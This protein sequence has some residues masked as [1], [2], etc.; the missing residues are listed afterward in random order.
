[1]AA[2]WSWWPRLVFP[3]VC[4]FHI[5][6]CW[7]NLIKVNVRNL[8]QMV[9]H[10]SRSSW[11]GCWNGEGHLVALLVYMWATV[12]SASPPLAAAHSSWARAPPSWVPRPLGAIFQCS[13][14]GPRAIS[15]I[16]ESS[17]EI[18]H[19]PMTGLPRLN[20]M[21]FLC[22]WLAFCQLSLAVLLIVGWSG[23]LIGPY[24]HPWQIKMNYYLINAIGLA[25]AAFQ[26]M[27]PW[28]SKEPNKR[29]SQKG[30]CWLS[31]DQL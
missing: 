14:R 24:M 20:E 23:A 13:K 28:S 16:S 12:G 27:A 10:P 11:T 7:W 5:C 17:G 15:N 2:E 30:T 6:L 9:R 3:F 22:C 19:L 21:S 18:I 31:Q 1:M 4:A 26:S 8:S 29:A 25:N